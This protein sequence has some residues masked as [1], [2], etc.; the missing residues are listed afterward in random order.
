MIKF[1]YSTF[2][3]NTWTIISANVFDYMLYVATTVL[4]ENSIKKKSDNASKCHLK[5]PPNPK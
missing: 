3:V 1:P 4:H 2:K 5:I